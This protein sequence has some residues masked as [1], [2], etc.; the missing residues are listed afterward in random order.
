[1]YI[2]LHALSCVISLLTLTTTVN[3]PYNDV[4]TTMLTV[5]S[6]LLLSVLLALLSE[7]PLCAALPVSADYV[8]RC[9]SAF[10]RILDKHASDIQ[11]L[12]KLVD[13]GS[14]VPAFGQKADEICNQVS[15]K[16]P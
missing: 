10:C 13:Q 5:L 14:C 6:V 9:D 8:Q 16:S 12:K 11:D 15:N 4:M 7:L 1:M 3:I 2:P